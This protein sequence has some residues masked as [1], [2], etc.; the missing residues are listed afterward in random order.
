[1]KKLISVLII[2]TM[3]ISIFAAG[4]GDTA[5]DNGT[6]SATDNGSVSATVSATDFYNSVWAL[7]SEDEM[8]PMAG[9]DF[10]HANMEKPDVYDIVANKDAFVSTYLVPEDIYTEITGDVITAVH[11]MNVNTFCSAVFNVKDASKITALADAYKKAVQSNMWMCGM[12]DT[13]VVIAVGDLMAVAYGED[14]LVKTFVDKCTSANA[15]AKVLVE[16][17]AVEG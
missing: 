13:V 16:A 8:Y 3:M 6:G 17:P 15:G 7:Y 4:C 9:G 1:M 2:A 14:S 10:D 12:P 5:G 11:M